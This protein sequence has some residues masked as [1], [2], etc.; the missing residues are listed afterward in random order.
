MNES[1]VNTTAVFDENLAPYFQYK[2]HF[3]HSCA[4]KKKKKKK[5]LRQNNG[6][7]NI[8]SLLWRD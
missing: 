7:T 3:D 6:F 8:E 1:S 5:I 2:L 4:S